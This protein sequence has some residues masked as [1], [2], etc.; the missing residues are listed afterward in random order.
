MKLI[1][2]SERWCEMV[3][4]QGVTSA[5]SACC[6]DVATVVC[7]R[8]GLALCDEHESVCDRCGQSFCRGCGHICEASTAQAA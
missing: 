4:S 1:V 7:G 8:C 3:L 5:Q 6:G 2:E